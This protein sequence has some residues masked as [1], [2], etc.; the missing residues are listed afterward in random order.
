[1]DRLLSD[2]IA[3]DGS[4]P[5]DRPEVAH[6]DAVAATPGGE[7]GGGVASAAAAAAPW[8]RWR[9]SWATQA[10][11]ARRRRRSRR[12]SERADATAA[13]CEVRRFRE[14]AERGRRRRFK[15]WDR[16]GKDGTTVK[17]ENNT[18]IGHKRPQGSLPAL[19]FPR[20]VQ[21]FEVLA[22]FRPR[23]GHRG[24]RWLPV[25]KCCQVYGRTIGKKSWRAKGGKQQVP[26]EV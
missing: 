12:I 8:R 11:R 25:V 13:A 21:H 26:T 10:S 16:V 24:R 18:N 6:P 2:N 15:D 4:S 7:G 9:R 23:E 17:C 20:A 22:A 1:M 3:P 19:P 14:Q 5:T